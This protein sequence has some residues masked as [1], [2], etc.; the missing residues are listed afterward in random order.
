MLHL[1]RSQSS[2]KNRRI[3]CLSTSS[4]Q[5]FNH[6]RSIPILFQLA[7]F[8]LPFLLIDPHGNNKQRRHW[9]FPF[10][11]FII[12]NWC[13]IQRKDWYLMSSVV[14]MTNIADHE[15]WRQVVIVVLKPIK[16]QDIAC[17]PRL[18]TNPPLT[19]YSIYKHLFNR[20]LL[21]NTSWIRRSSNFYCTSSKRGI[22]GSKRLKL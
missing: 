22:H 7:A 8:W 11:L 17:F 4:N 10:S 21:A 12:Q 6:R 19:S 2:L 14:N 13:F 16:Q 3:T 1:S 20:E 15:Q 9:P 18:Y 5:H